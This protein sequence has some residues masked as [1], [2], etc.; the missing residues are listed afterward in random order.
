[1]TDV[2][3]RTSVPAIDSGCR[4]WMN[5]IRGKGWRGA[6]LPKLLPLLRTAYPPPPFTPYTFTLPHTATEWLLLCPLTQTFPQK[7]G[8]KLFTPFLLTILPAPPLLPP[9]RLH[10]GRKGYPASLSPSWPPPCFPSPRFHTH[11]YTQ[12]DTH[13]HEHRRTYKLNP[14]GQQLYMR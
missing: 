8:R 4:G 11:A 10:W 14:P 13:G 2:Q 7:R 9:Q 5:E 12:T 1:M 6:S 3:T